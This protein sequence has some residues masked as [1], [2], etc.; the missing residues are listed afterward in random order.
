M[1]HPAVPHNP[2]CK[3]PHTPDTA[4]PVDREKS[5]YPTHDLSKHSTHPKALHMARAL[6]STRSSHANPRDT[7]YTLGTVRRQTTS[8]R[9]DRRACLC[10]RRRAASC[11][12]CRCLAFYRGSQDA[13]ARLL[14]PDRWVRCRA[15]RRG[16]G[17]RLRFGPL[18]EG[19]GVS[20]CLSLELRRG[21][22]G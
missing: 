5:V 17:G 14:V 3:P 13:R 20:H 21:F 12:R 8:P 10:A 15:R 1:D 6:P 11:R 16:G 4:P 9:W 18:G 2:S 22:V 19:D 7:P